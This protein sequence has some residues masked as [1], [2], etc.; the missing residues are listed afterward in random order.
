MRKSAENL[1]AANNISN[2]L[3]FPVLP[4]ANNQEEPFI[5]SYK[6]PMTAMG[7]GFG[8]SNAQMGGGISRNPLD[9]QSL[10]SH[11]FDYSIHRYKSID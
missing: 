2:G 11:P 10:D 5:P 6:H 7:T 4:T 1:N 3:P 8:G 9:A